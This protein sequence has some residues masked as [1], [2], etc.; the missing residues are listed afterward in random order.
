M[1]DHSIY[2]VTVNCPYRRTSYMSVIFDGTPVTAERE[3]SECAA[4]GLDWLS[5]CHE[6]AKRNFDACS[7]AA[8]I[9]ERAVWEASDGTIYDTDET[10][11]LCK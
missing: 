3:V 8:R 9:I 4:R 11:T 6:I 1:D 7:G 2:I 10:I 5:H